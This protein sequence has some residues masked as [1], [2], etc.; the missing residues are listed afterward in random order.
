MPY[1]NLYRSLVLLR[2]S[3]ALA[4]FLHALVRL[5]NSSFE[6]FGDFL[7]RKHFIYGTVIVWILTCFEL[8]GS[9]LLAF[10]R[11][12]KPIALAFIFILVVGIIIIHF[13]LGWF[14]GEHGTG[15]I[16]YSFILIMA[17]LTII[18]A[19]NQKQST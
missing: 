19:V 7:E 4:F 3:I 16:E 17:L 13:E 8:L 10:G 5:F 14:V 2:I 18:A 1:L 9:I 15:G 12:T 6:R 11:Y